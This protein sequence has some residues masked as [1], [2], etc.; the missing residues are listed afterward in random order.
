MVSFEDGVEFIS[1]YVSGEKFAP[2]TSGATDVCFR[3]KSLSFAQFCITSLVAYIYIWLCFLQFWHWIFLWLVWHPKPQ[4]QMVNAIDFFSDFCQWASI[5]NF[6]VAKLSTSMDTIIWP[7]RRCPTVFN[8][9][10]KVLQSNKSW[11]VESIFHFSLYCSLSFVNFRN[12]GQDMQSAMQPV[13]LELF[14]AFD[15]NL[16]IIW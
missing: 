11:L 16:L 13:A 9:E 7:C 4:Y 1:F 10:P 5:S 8:W 15:S 6:D 3:N 12:C 2:L 14:A